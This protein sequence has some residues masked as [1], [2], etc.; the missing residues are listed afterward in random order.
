MA[1]MVGSR[2]VRLGSFPG[3]E[4]EGLGLFLEDGNAPCVARIVY[5]PGV[6]AAAREGLEREVARA[7][8]ALLVA[9]A[10][11]NA[12]VVRYAALA[13]GGIGGRSDREGQALADLLF[14]H[15][16]GV[17]AAA[18]YGL[19]QMGEE[20]SP[21]TDRL[22]DLLKNDSKRVVRIQAARAHWLVSG[23]AGP[24][25][26]ELHK[27]IQCDD[28]GLC[29]DA[30]KALAA[31]GPAAEPAVPVLVGMLS[32]SEL[33]HLAVVVLGAIGP[34]AK[35]AVPRLESVAEEVA[36]EDPDLAAE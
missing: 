10:D 15:Q 35:E 17:R 20:A 1:H 9:L 36:D 13:V 3:R 5:L 34:A 29:R 30:L 31:L 12:E 18:A 33:R 16:T 32:R 14:A 24:G 27:G 2:V 4:G 8:E 7:A 21:Y 26:E 25:L 23:D 6:D 11:D 19:G 28:P 22:L